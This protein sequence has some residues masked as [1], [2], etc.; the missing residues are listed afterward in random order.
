RLLPLLRLARQEGAWARLSRGNWSAVGHGGTVLHGVKAAFT[1]MPPVSSP[2]RRRHVAGSWH[3]LGCA[4]SCVPPSSQLVPAS[5]AGTRN[6]LERAQ[7][8]CHVLCGPPTK[9]I[10]LNAH[11]AT[12]SREP[13]AARSRRGQA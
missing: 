2:R 13:G 1:V 11:L 9:R 4:A 8:L 7:N 12:D 3:R 6:R 5:L 10:L